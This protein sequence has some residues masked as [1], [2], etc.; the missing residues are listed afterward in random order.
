MFVSLVFF[1]EMWVSGFGSFIRIVLAC[2]SVRA[3]LQGAGCRG[4]ASQGVGALEARVS[5]EQD[6]L[7]ISW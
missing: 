6:I 3:E 5:V 1:P 2:S 4:M 7:G